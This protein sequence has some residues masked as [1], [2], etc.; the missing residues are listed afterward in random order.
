M[1]QI[2]NASLDVFLLMLCLPIVLKDSFWMSEK[3]LAD[4]W[5]RKTSLTYRALLTLCMLLLANGWGAGIFGVQLL[6]EKASLRGEIELF[7]YCLVWLCIVILIFLYQPFL[8]LVIL[9]FV[10]PAISFAS[11][12]SIGEID[13]LIYTDNDY[14]L[15]QME[16]KR[17]DNKTKV[18]TYFCDHGI[19]GYQGPIERTEIAL[20]P[21]IILTYGYKRCR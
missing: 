17:I 16:T 4:P 10:A 19:F 12:L 5:R 7:W 14:C 21:G 11:L 2:F 3:H 6:L 8:K 15:S 18:V 20:L 1:N 13:H 9:I